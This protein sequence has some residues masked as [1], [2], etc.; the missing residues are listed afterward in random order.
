MSIFFFRND[1]VRDNLDQSLIE[2]TDIFIKN[3]IPITHAVEPA[4][5]TQAVIDWLLEVKQ[6][7]P[8]IISIM[9]H[10]YDHTVKNKHKKGIRK[11]I[12]GV[13]K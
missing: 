2:L 1:D 7:Y 6:S 10:G 4:N 9:Q 12:R 13:H 11:G 3:Q 5:I 8:E